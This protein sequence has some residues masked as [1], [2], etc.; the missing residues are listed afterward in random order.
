MRFLC[1]VVVDEDKLA[2]LSKQEAQDLDDVSLDHDQKLRQGGRFL[3]AA[4]LEPVRTSKLVRVKDGKVIVTDSPFAE[5]KEQ[6][7]GFILIEAKNLDEAI[8]VASQIPAGRQL[9]GIIVR[10]VKELTHSESPRQ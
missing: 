1:L 4:A 8:E 6:I 5:T 9:G 3:A 2:A 10:P 7:G